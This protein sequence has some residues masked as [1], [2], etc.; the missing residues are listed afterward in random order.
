MTETALPAASAEAERRA[1]LIAGAFAY[2]MW[3][4]LPLYLTALGF[5]DVREV[6]SQRIL[7][8]VPAALIAVFVTSGWQRGWNEIV[9]A[10]KPR[11][12]ATLALSACFI[13]FNW[14]LYVWLVLHGRV[15][16]SSLAYFL[17]PL[18]AVAVG[19]IFFGE[20]VHSSHDMTLYA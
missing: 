4:F 11:L 9:A 20:P 16:E 18:V 12:L 15:I 19:T 7:W 10:M 6:L 13:F 5:A 14:G 1:G 2:V 3:G 17:A 8:C